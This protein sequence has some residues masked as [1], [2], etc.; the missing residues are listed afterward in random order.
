[1]NFSYTVQKNGIINNYILQSSPI[2]SNLPGYSDLQK[3]SGKIFIRINFRSL[4][5]RWG[6]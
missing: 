1:M 4:F 3:V 6:F 2:L 5:I